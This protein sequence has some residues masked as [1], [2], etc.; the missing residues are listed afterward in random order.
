[1]AR[2]DIITWL[3][4]TKYTEAD[5]ARLQRQVAK[6]LKSPHRFTVFADRDLK[7]VPSIKIKDPELCERSCFCRLRMFDPEWQSENGFDGWIISLD[8]DLVITGPL[9]DV[10]IPRS[11]FMILKGVNKVNPNPLNGSIMMLKAGAYP[12]V[13]QDFSLEA[14]DKI[15]KMEFADDQGW[16]WH[17]LP[18]ADGWQPGPDTGV[19]AFQ[20][21]GWPLETIGFNLPKDARVVA[22]IGKRKPSMYRN[23]PWIQKHWASV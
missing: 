21:P 19:Y 7:G 20:K 3:W 14:A 23:L 8:L 11:R 15:Q 2:L 6:Y 16:I 10:F 13:W 4:G 1:M 9:D 12:E 5:V 17:K 18:N 22:F